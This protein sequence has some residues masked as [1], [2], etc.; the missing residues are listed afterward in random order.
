ML[1][2]SDSGLLNHWVVTKVNLEY[3]HV[4]TPNT[5]YLIT[6]YREIPIRFK[7]KTENK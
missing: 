6:R 2:I 4:L 1:T 5:F 7:K 3:N